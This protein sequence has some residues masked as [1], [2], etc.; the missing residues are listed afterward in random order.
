KI[1]QSNATETHKTEIPFEINKIQPKFPLAELDNQILEV[2]SC[3]RKHGI[4]INEP[5]LK[6][7]ARKIAIKNNK[8]FFKA[9]NGWLDK[10][11]KRNDISFKNISGESQSAET[12]LIPDFKSRFKK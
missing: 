8:E 5:C 10:F 7:I 11:R 2:F 12:S 6:D 1:I 3:L 9:S 4:P